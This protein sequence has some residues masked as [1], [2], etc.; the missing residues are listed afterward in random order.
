MAPG[1]N[2]GAATPI[3]LEM[4]PALPP[5]QPP[6]AKDSKNSNVGD[7]SDGSAAE[8]EGT[9]RRKILN[10]AEA[11][12]RSLAILNNRNGDWG[13]EAVRSAVSLPAADALKLH[14][15]D[16]IAGDVPSLLREIDGRLVNVAGAPQRLATAGL[17]VVTVAPDWR[18]RWLAVITDPNIAYL[19]MLLGAYGLIFE[20]TS[21]GAV[22]PGVVGTISLV[23]ALYALN[24]LPVDYAGVGLVLLGIMLMIA[25]AFIGA[26]GMLGVGGLAAFIFGSVMIFQRDTSGISVSIA[27]V[28]GAAVFSACF[29]LL[30]IAMLLRSR[31]RPVITGGEALIGAEG[32]VVEGN[33]ASIRVR[34]N[35]EVWLARAKGALPRDGRIRVVGRDGLVLTVEPS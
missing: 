13:A 29:F 6:S 5:G 16:V 4:L 32:E 23:V 11:Y 10:D 19:M 33:G 25:E 3:Q 22:L 14:V 2:L 24:L 27:V 15:I 17:D 7:A 35:G 30:V 20:L 26:F 31:R 12:I 28:I 21:P 8:G 1:T 34:V 9:E 18:I